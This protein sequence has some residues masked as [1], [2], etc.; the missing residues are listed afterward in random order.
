MEHLN[1]KLKVAIV[2]P[3]QDS[4]Q[5]SYQCFS[6]QPRHCRS[7]LLHFIISL[8]KVIASKWQALCPN[9][10]LS[11][12]LLRCCITVYRIQS[13]GRFFVFHPFLMVQGVLSNNNN[14]IQVFRSKFAASNT[15]WEE[16]WHCIEWSRI[17]MPLRA[18]SIWEKA[19]SEPF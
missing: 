16:Q 15:L 2:V 9:C 19:T 4:Q 3:R 14:Q 11:S 10:K 7:C 6:Q 17:M 18:G 8:I 12:R 5:Y 1:C 13:K